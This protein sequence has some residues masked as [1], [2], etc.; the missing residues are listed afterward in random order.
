MSDRSLTA[1]AVRR[2]VF[3]W[4]VMIALVVLGGFAFRRLPIDQFPDVDFPVVTVQ[5][6]YPGAAAQTVERELSR[7][8]ERAFQPI[9]GVRRV[10]STSVDGIS[11]VV[12][13]FEL[14]RDVDV[15]AADIRTRLDAIRAALPR[16]IDPPIVQ[17]LDPS[18]QPILSL[19]LT[20]ARIPI[21]GL[22]RLADEEVRRALE[23]VSGVGEVRVVGGQR[24]EIRVLM[25][26]DAMQAL[27]AGP[28]AVI[29][30][31]ARQNQENPLGRLNRGPSETTIRFMGKVEEPGDFADVLIGVR[32]AQQQPVRLG[33]VARIVDTTAEARSLAF[34]AAGAAAQPTT[35]VSIDVLKSSGA[36]TVEVSDAVQR[37]VVALSSQLP[38]G[39]SLVVVRDNAALIRQSVEDVI[40]ELVLG[41]VLT[42]VIVFLFLGDVKATAITALSLPISVI[43]TFVLMGALGFTLNVMTLLALSICIGILID[44]AIVVIENI[45]RRAQQGLSSERAAVEGAREIALAVLA[46]TFTIVAVF[47]PVAFMRGLIGRFFFEFG[48]TVSWA[49]LVSLF[50]SFTLTPMLAVHWRLGG[51]TSASEPARRWRRVLA[52]VDRALSALTAR[53]RLVIRWSL[54]HRRLTMGLASASFVGAGA[55]APL[56]GGGFAPD[57]DAGEL[58]VQ[59]R[60]AEGASLEATAERARAVAA[61]LRKRPEVRFVYVAV[62][63]GQTSSIRDAEAF[64]KLVPRKQRLASQAQLADTLREALQGLQGIEL[65]ILQPGGP[66]GAVSPLTIQLRGPDADVLRQISDTLAARMR[67][68]RGVVDVLSSVGDRQPDV[69]VEPIREVATRLGLDATAITAAVRPLF[70]GEIAGRWTDPTGEERDVVVTLADDHR[71]RISQLL[72]LPIAVPNQRSENQTFVPLGQIARVTQGLAPSRIERYDLERSMTLSAGISGATTLADASSS[73]QRQIEQLAVPQG[74]RITL[75]GDAEQLNE[76]VG[77]LVEAIVLAVIL[78]FL[79]LASQFESLSQPL[80]IMLAL[81]L[82]IVG[83][84]IALLMTN[85]TLNIMSMIG[86]IM[87]LGLVTKNAILLV[88]HANARRADG[89]PLAI[90]IEDAGADRLRPILMTTVA[91]I[92]GMLPIALALG[93]GGDFRA[94]M[95]RAVIGGLITSTLLTLVVV[96][97]GYSWLVRSARPINREAG[98]IG[99][100]EQQMA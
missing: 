24:R 94:P 78:I 18:A 22:T 30:A 70:N 96:P 91:M 38:S 9:E 86:V 51:E 71:R 83:V 19:A 95:A 87:L 29:D 61:I 43:S 97:V 48:L 62:G 36:N 82:S 73:L 23:A 32:G 53:Y 79:I 17:K 46:T 47:V 98:T 52:A 69:R 100:P 85:T 77:Y 75:G 68:T 80:A 31:I 14:G 5:T 66:A 20:G 15:G 40:S 28:Q 63:S 49:V 6:A 84:M 45:V 59:F 88:D 55:L 90:A 27:N 81:P 93:E 13:E 21:E 44:D 56:V 60:S 25:R 7:K 67:S 39:A 54:A 16:D 72:T 57:T 50:V 58:I 10:T 3:T 99:L 35:A 42:V 65:A 76:T 33:E 12:V 92:A 8:L 89:V 1:I 64:V 26:P 37:A 41:G 2:P 4:M 74:Y 11:Q 34:L